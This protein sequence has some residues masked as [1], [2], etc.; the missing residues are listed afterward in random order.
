MNNMKVILEETYQHKAVKMISD[1]FS[2]QLC[3]VRQLSVNNYRVIKNNEIENRPVRYR[4]QLWNNHGM[5]ITLKPMKNLIIFLLVLAT[6]MMAKGQS[7]PAF[8]QY[9]LNPVL[10]NPAGAGHHKYTQFFLSYRQ[11]WMGIPDSPQTT[12]LTVNSPLEFQ[13]LNVGLT[14]YSDELHIINNSGAWANIAYFIDLT[15]YQRL[16]FGLAPG[17]EYS[18]L[19]FDRIEGSVT[20]ATLL[21]SNQSMKFNT[22]AGLY[23]TFKDLSIGL[24]AHNLLYDLPA[25]TAIKANDNY[26]YN[27]LRQ[28]TVTAGYRYQPLKSKALYIE[29]LLM[30]QADEQLSFR[31]DANLVVNW[32]DEI[33]AGVAYRYPYGLG[34][35]ASA[36]V[37]GIFAV[38]YSYD[39]PVGAV[40]ELTTGSHE[41]TLGYRLYRKGEKP[42]RVRD[43]YRSTHR[44]QEYQSDLLDESDKK[45]EKEINRARKEESKQLLANL[46]RDEPEVNTLIAR[47]SIEP[48]EI[49]NGTEDFNY[50]I[51]VGVAKE[52]GDIKLLENSIKHQ[53]GVYAQYRQTTDK[54]FYLLYTAQVATH[55]EAIA[56]MNELSQLDI[57]RITSH[58]PWIYKAINDL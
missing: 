22:H 24:A 30:A 35:V 11:Q 2:E 34:F 14:L 55:E 48:N 16:Y 3:F 47:E 1:V 44:Q 15:E 50:Y 45:S 5:A 46:K 33:K 43:Y 39:Y 19:Y 57:K 17:V 25:S 27:I 12:Y 56:K 42:T 26:V 7:Y 28:Y 9:Y 21:S 53:F 58:K 49:E 10:N 23:Y 13:N 38:G 32:K 37:H 6:A 52:F 36:L 51:V 20:D 29:P 18:R 40:S 8:S 31:G 4:I 54:A 41:V